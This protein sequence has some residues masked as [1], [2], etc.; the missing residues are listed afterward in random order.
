MV[1]TWRHL[2]PPDDGQ[3]HFVDISSPPIDATGCTA[4]SVTTFYIYAIRIYLE[5]ATTWSVKT[6]QTTYAEPFYIP[7]VANYCDAASSP[8]DF[9]P[10]NDTTLAEADYFITSAYCLRFGAGDPWH[11]SLGLTQVANAPSS[12]RP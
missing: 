2:A 4:C 12:R 11:C 10:P 5:V 8:P 3:V 9:D 6:G 7:P 1:V